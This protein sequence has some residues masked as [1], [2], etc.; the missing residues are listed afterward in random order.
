MKYTKT[1]KEII[2][3]LVKYEG[4]T[5][6]IADALTQSKVLERH[7]VVIVPNGNEFFAF[8]DKEL[9]PD[10]DNIVYLAELLT[11][12][13]S[14]TTNRD[15]LLISQ[16]GPCHVIGKERT[17]YIK[18]NVIL[19]NEKDYIVTEG[20]G[21]P[22]YF[23]FPVSKLAYSYSISQELKELVQHNFKSEEEIHFSKQQFVSWVAIGVS[24]LLGILGVIF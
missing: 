5:R 22:N 7:G 10:W 12:I 8:F 18:L 9:Y 13:D 1:E 3:A 14:L 4:M 24:L 23:K 15:I 17:K 11:V 6:T 20:I 21:G 2:I 19:V 16:K